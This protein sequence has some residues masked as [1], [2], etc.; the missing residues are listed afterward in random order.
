MR[1]RELKKVV[2]SRQATDGDGDGVKINRLAA[3]SNL[4]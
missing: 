1:P 3:G 2:S 4:K